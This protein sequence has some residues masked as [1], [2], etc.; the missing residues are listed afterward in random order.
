M[1]KARTMKKLAQSRVSCWAP[2]HL[3]PKS[4]C[5]FPTCHHA[6][7]NSIPILVL[8][9]CSEPEFQTKRHVKH[10]ML[11]KILLKSELKPLWTVLG[12]SVVSL[13]I[14][15]GMRPRSTSSWQGYSMNHWPS[16]LM[17]HLRSFK[18]YWCLLP[19]CM[20]IIA[21]CWA[22]GLLKISQT[23][24]RCRELGEPWNWN[25]LMF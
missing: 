11:N 13:I 23:K 5:H 24:I 4:G 16:T 2:Q 3:Q 1:F 8:P 15:W 14:C 20:I 17:I 12:R 7:F 10:G 6:S 9:V 19:C 25:I 21:W 18:N 22:S